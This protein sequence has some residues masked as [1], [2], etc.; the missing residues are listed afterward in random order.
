MTPYT[1]A[2]VNALRPTFLTLMAEARRA[3]PQ[4]WADAHRVPG[5]RGD[6]FARLVAREGQLRGHR[7]G[8]NA[9][10]G[11]L[12]DLS[13]D[14]IVFP[15]LAGGAG[16]ASGRFPSVVIIDFIASAGTSAADLAWIDQTGPTIT[17]GTR[18]GFVDPR[19]T[20]EE[21]GTGG[22]P[23]V[24]PPVVTPPVVVPP[25]AAPCQFKGDTN[26]PLRLAEIQEALSRLETRQETLFEQQTKRLFG[27]GPDKN[28]GIADLVIT[29]LQ[30]NR[31]RVKF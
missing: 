30:N 4:A 21:L 10:R 11:N 29:W 17:A 15:V 9:K 12:G 7:V 19:V 25:P 2:E 31:I 14:C 3:Y 24:P 23:I 28:P 22:T 6:L 26:T 13:Q 1:Y 8:V 5:A 20:H 27:E 18:G 16:D